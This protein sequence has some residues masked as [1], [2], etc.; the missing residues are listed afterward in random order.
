MTELHPQYHT[1]NVQECFLQVKHLLEKQMLVETVTHR[2]ELPRD[3]RH[4]LL[5]K[6]VHKRHQK[7]LRKKLDE[8]H[9]ADIAYILEA[10][11]IEQRLMVWDQV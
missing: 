6:M 8:L 1:D 2:Q 5:D 10:L 7:E 3:E 9:A 4:E 11:P